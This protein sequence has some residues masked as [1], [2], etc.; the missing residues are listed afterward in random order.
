MGYD[1]VQIVP[2]VGRSGGLA[3]AWISTK[4]TVTI[5]EKNRQFFH[6][7]CQFGQE[8]PFI[9]TSVY[10][11]PHSDLRSVLWDNLLRLSCSVNLPWCVI[12]DFNDVLTSAERVGGRSGNF[13]RME[14]SS[15]L[16]PVCNSHSEVVLHVLRYCKVVK[17]MWKVLVHPRFQANF[18]SVPLQDWFQ[19][20]LKE[21]LGRS[22]AS[23]WSLTFGVGIWRMWSW[24]NQTV[25]DPYF[26]RPP[27]PASVILNTQSYKNVNQPSSFLQIQSSTAVNFNED[28]A[29]HGS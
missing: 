1:E 13:R 12:G 25:F 15:S 16:C 20:N 18:F 2:S 11:I 28:T 4:V 23:N 22:S 7:K 14:C 24:R 10:A 26:S 6:L 17:D 27:D 3:V 21:D 8:L 29:E 9:L 5:L 19:Y